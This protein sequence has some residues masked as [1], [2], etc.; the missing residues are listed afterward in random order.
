P[1]LARVPPEDVSEP[2]GDHDA[3]TVVL[4]RPDGVL[5]GRAGAE[6]G[7]GDQ[8]A[9]VPERLLVQDEVRVRAPGGEQGVLETGP[10]DPF[11][12][13]RRDNLVG[14]YVGPP[15]RDADPGVFFERFHVTAPDGCCASWLWTGSLVEPFAGSVEVFR[16]RQ[17]AAD[18][19]GRGHQR[20]NQVRAATL[21]LASLEV[22]VRGGSAALPRGQ[23]IRV[24]EIGR[25]SCRERV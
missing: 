17:R 2:G 18:R 6:G 20:G 8:H 1:L 24:H 13:D 15:E 9:P 19:G 12:V 3:E 11:E 14:V 22:A 5:P 10:G 25:A 16:R 23:L 4:Q 7:P 21:A